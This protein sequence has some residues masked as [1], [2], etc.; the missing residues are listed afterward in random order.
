MNKARLWTSVFIRIGIAAFLTGICQ[1]MFMPGF[2]Q[3]L[4]LE[5]FTP[6]TIGAIS[7]AY[8]AA[9]LFARAFSGSL[10]DSFGRRRMLL[11]GIILLSAPIFGFMYVPGR[12]AT[13]FFRVVQGVGAST[14][15]IAVG[16]MAP[17]V[18]PRE[19]MAEGIGYFGLFTT[20]ASAIGPALGIALLTA[21]RPGGFFAVGL[22]SSLLSFPVALSLRY[23]KKMPPQ[24]AGAQV[25]HETGVL[26]RFVS[27][28]A[29]PAAA[30][31]AMISISTSSIS[32]FISPHALSLGITTASLFFVIQ[33]V[34]MMIARIFSGR[35]LEKLGMFRALLIGL[36]LDSASL[37]LLA[38]MNGRWMLYL[39][40]ALRGTGGGISLPLLNV[41]AV[42]HAERA[43]RGRATSTYYAAYDV[44]SGI[45]G[46]VWG[47]TAQHL[48]G[49]P[50]V[51]L[52][53][54]VFYILTAIVTFRLTRKE[55]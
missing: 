27:R 9:S 20:L 39:S 25:E 6:S 26:A 19:R 13:V 48:G 29:L 23:E 35:L 4:Q 14:A 12:E 31:F 15:S 8:T 44:G 50:V 43:E 36:V 5:G 54:A 45:G 22:F 33:A 30:I 24:P 46:I 28:R 49:Y 18:L 55:N 42:E 37:L 3:F 10:T 1:Q 51:F 52:S 2:P 32:N 53:A 17:D 40:A 11:A 21:G 47:F 38:G 41:M 16:T 7:A 34:F